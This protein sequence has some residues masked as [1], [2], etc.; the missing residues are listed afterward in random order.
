M[1]ALTTHP[2]TQAPHLAPPPWRSVARTRVVLAVVLVELIVAAM[3]VYGLWVLRRQV[4]DGELRTLG[5]LSAAMA[6]QADGM[7]DVADAVLRATRTELV[8]GLMQPGTAAADALLHS[9]V[10]ALPK[11]HALLLFDTEGRRVAASHEGGQPPAAVMAREYF[12]AARANAEAAGAPVLFV[13]RPHPDTIDGKPGIAVA[14]DWRD[15]RG[16]FRGVIVLEAQPDFLDGGF[17]RIAPTPDTSLAIYRR[18]RE[19]VSDGPGDGVQ[20]LLPARIMDSLWADASAEQPRLMALADGRQRLVAAHRLQRFPL[21][22]VVTRDARVAM[23]DW[24]DQAWLVG[25]FAAS[26]LAMTLFLTLRNAREQAL[27]RASQSALLAE[28]ER[29]V[30]AFQAAQEGHWEWDPRSGLSHLSP[31]MKELL[32]IARDTPSDGLGGQTNLLLRASLHPDDI[33]PLRAAF[34]A[35]QQGRTPVFDH[36]VRVRQA[37]GRWRYVR[38]RGTAWR[39]ADGQTQLFSGTAS[40]V[41]AER[42]AQAQQQL[43]QEQLQRARKLE[44]LGTL[45]GGVAHDFNNILA[46]VIGYGELARSTAPEGSAQARQIDQVMQAGLRGKALVERILSFSRSSPRPHLVFLL[47]PVVDEVLQLLAASLPAEVRLLPQ[48]DAPE[49]AVSGDATMVFEAAMNLCTNAIQ[50]M[51]ATGRGGRLVVALSVVDAQQPLALYEGRL[52]AGR[53]AC[54]SV[55]DDG[56]GITPEVRRR[57]FEP[58]FTTKGAQHGTGLGLAVVHGAMHDMGGAVD[59]QS[60][61]GQGACFT[62]YVPCTDALPPP[63]AAAQDDTAPLGAGQAVLIVDDDAALVT[64]AEEMLAELGYESFGLASSLQALAEFRSDPQ[65]FDLVLTDEQMPGMTGTDL[66]AALHALRPGLPVVLASGYGG[67]QLEQRAA[68]AGVAVLLRKPLR[69]AELAQALARALG[70]HTTR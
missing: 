59:V 6:T 18:D 67:P 53:Y 26:A 11:F 66:A 12:T 23:A 9:R 52:P 46:A 49:V 50:A 54:L 2:A 16:V 37:E 56:P 31:R 61:P 17:E 5:S 27:R 15:A 48:L 22:V 60:E 63:P 21:M 29:A 13:G 39:G 25:S 55:A 70:P 34:S 42:E 40:D 62:L 36:I 68:Q 20:R 1:T 47:Q 19:L 32:G 3:V 35:H 64:L 28:Q 69:R 43:L 24:S 4:L 65:R 58:F 44:A 8:D 51:Q 30:R 14:M 10:A 38:A 41:S 45:A 33:A 57:L 7:L